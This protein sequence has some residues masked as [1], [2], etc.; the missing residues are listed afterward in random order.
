MVEK[1]KEQS[2]GL[3]VEIKTNLSFSQLREEYARASIFW[4]ATGFGTDEEVHPE[5][6]EHFGITT[7]EAM[8]AGCVPIVI[9]KGGQKEIVRPEE[10]GF[11]WTEVEDLVRYTRRL[12]NERELFKKLSRQAHLDSQIYS[13]RRFNEQI[14]ELVE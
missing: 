11:C 1:L 9:N 8:A 2:A 7:V 4:V 10:N 5:A 12:I 3:P 13:E 6:M 14:R